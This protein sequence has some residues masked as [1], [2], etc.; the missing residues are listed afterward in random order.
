MTR[1]SRLSRLLMATALVSIMT[2]TSGFADTA[3]YDNLNDTLRHELTEV[4][5]TDADIG[6]LTYE[7]VGK[8]SAV[9]AQKGNPTD[10]KLA[11]ERIIAGSP[12]KPIS[13]A[14]VIS[15]V[16][17]NVG[18]DLKAA[19]IEGVTPNDLRLGTVEKLSK[20][21]ASGDQSRHKAEAMAILDA[22]PRTAAQMTSVTD[23]PANGDLEMAV[24]RDIKSVGIEAR[25]P[26]NMTIGQLTAISKVFQ[27]QRDQGARATQVRKILGM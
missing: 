19:G 17:V 8:L 18:A 14:Q 7:Q 10:Q 15:G 22:S 2:A 4:G 20:V 24:I 16:R 11:A 23:V 12:A 21:F 26:Q 3:A 27:E 25:H 1:F 13:P 5:V 6:H 9:F